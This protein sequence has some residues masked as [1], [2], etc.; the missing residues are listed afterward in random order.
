MPSAQSP[1]ADDSGAPRQALHAAELAFMHPITGQPLRFRMPLPQDL[2][3]WLLTLR[4]Q[5]RPE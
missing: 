4:R 3:E 2:K 1:Q 5:V